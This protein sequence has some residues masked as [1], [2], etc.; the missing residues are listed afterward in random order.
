VIAPTPKR[1]PRRVAAWLA[2]PVAFAVAAAPVAAARQVR[3]WPIEVAAPGLTE[4]ELDA[5]ALAA[6]TDSGGV[7]VLDA[8]G[9][10]V[11]AARRER[12][13]GTSCRSVEVRGLERS[14]DRWRLRLRVPGGNFRHDVLRFELDSVGLGADCR[15]VSVGPDGRSELARGDLFR[16]GEAEGLAGSRLVYPPTEAT[17]L[18][19]DWPAEAG[20][21]AV[22][23]VEVCAPATGD[24]GPWLA[25]GELRGERLGARQVRFRAPRPALSVAVSALEVELATAPAEAVGFRLRAAGAGG[26]REL[27]RGLW[28]GGQRRLHLELGSLR[29]DERALLL[30]LHGSAP[31]RVTARWRA[32]PQRVRF[33]ARAAGVHRLRIPGRRAQ[34]PSSGGEAVVVDLGAGAAA[35]PSEPSSAALGATVP[36]VDFVARWPVLAAAQAGEPIALAID[37]PVRALARPDLADLR[38]ISGGRWVP[39]RIEAAGE[40]SSRQ[41]LAAVAPRPDRDGTSV[42]ELELSA[43]TLGRAPHLLLRAP[44]EAAPFEREVRVRLSTTVA[45]REETRPLGSATWRCADGEAVPCEL[46]LPLPARTEGRLRLELS[47]GD[48]APL[49]ALD[50]ERIGDGDRLVALWPGGEVELAAG[51]RELEPP[52]FDL[53]PLEVALELSA[54]VPARLGPASEPA[55]AP[56]YERQ[57]RWLLVAAVILAAGGLLVLLRRLVGAGAP[58][59]QPG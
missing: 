18:E 36:A 5:A 54:P 33:E 1:E 29:S 9:A 15:L 12:D 31:D 27:G 53:A 22:R 45:G 2:A 8:A 40:A 13:A 57:A 51:A 19:L 46:A 47:D 11:P 14:R 3:E 50:L 39:S 37:D 55:L 6:L 56:W 42:V 32:V 25:A 41:W 43:A 10:A 26:W 49:S 28:P 44:A 4:V 59:E 23:A 21:P 24:E 17:E 7:V 20:F 48:S 58:P 52:R 35:A 16:I 38:L 30:D 34:A